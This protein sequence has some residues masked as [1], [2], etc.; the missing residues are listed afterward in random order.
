MKHLKLFEDFLNEELQ[1]KLLK[2]ASGFIEAIAKDMKARKVIKR[3]DNIGKFEATN[4]VTATDNHLPSWGKPHGLIPKNE[5]PDNLSTA[6]RWW[7]SMLLTNENEFV[8][9]Y[10]SIM[11]DTSK[12]YNVAK[13]MDPTEL[14]IVS[15]PLI[16]DSKINELF[17]DKIKGTYGNDIYDFTRGKISAGPKLGNKPSKILTYD[18]KHTTGEAVSFDEAKQTQE[19]K[20]F[21]AKY[22]V[23]IISNPKQIKNGTFIFAIP[24]SHT[25]DLDK[26]FYTEGKEYVRDGFSITKSGYVRKTPLYSRYHWDSMQSA[27][28][29][30]F[31]ATSIEGWE[32]AI[33]IVD[34]YL[35]AM[36]EKMKNKGVKVLVDPKEREKYSGYIAGHNYGI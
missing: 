5:Q 24:V 19:M 4:W 32:S 1:I 18:F 8:Q 28:I 33:S 29:G 20:D 16:S 15:D 34:K 22:P 27:N 25:I 30:S 31:D 35:G 12:K 7:G 17:P 3:T 14:L 10:I 11:Y 23:E 6:S 36:I 2:D 13:E 9:L 21:L 26:Q